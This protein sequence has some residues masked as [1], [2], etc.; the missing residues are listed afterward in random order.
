MRSDSDFL[1]FPRNPTPAV[2]LFF[3]LHQGPLPL[4]LFLFPLTDGLFLGPFHL[5]KREFFPPVRPPTELVLSWYSGRRRVKVCSLE[6]VFSTSPLSQLYL[7]SLSPR[8]S[9][10]SR[11]TLILLAFDKPHDVFFPP[12]P[13]SS[14]L[15]PPFC[16]S[17]FTFKADGFSC[18]APSSS[19]AG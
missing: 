7:E 6:V 3:S 12:S 4:P 1:F 2:S 19:I 17:I 8:A 16:L 15:A 5:P 14:S 13:G 18:A 9:S 10:L 11:Q